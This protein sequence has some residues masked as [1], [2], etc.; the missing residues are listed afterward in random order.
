MSYLDR[1]PSY[2]NGSY[3]SSNQM[4]FGGLARRH[5][6]RVAK[7][8]NAGSSPL[9]NMRGARVN[10]CE[11]SRRFSSQSDGMA[12][13]FY[14]AL[15]KATAPT[16]PAQS[17]PS[18]QTPLDKKQLY[19]DLS[20]GANNGLDPWC[21]AAPLDEPQF[22]SIHNLPSLY[23]Y[24]PP[25]RPLSYQE[26]SDSDWPTYI[27]MVSSSYSDAGDSPHSSRSRYYDGGLS[28]DTTAVNSPELFSYQQFPEPKTPE[29][30]LSDSNIM[31]EVLVGVGLY[32]EPDTESW[33]APLVAHNSSMQSFNG[34]LFGSEFV[35]GKGLTL[36]EAFSPPPL[37][38]E[39]EQDDD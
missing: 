13:S 15:Q 1:T 2:S 3:D 34:P 19:I 29:A 17:Y 8:T 22:E 4:P 26:S 18:F 39:N 7:V 31:G 28:T 10:R 25:Q 38:S 16:M 9:G 33:D 37:E 35:P 32:N 24:S 14:A 5:S 27:P 11:P 36:E 21:H 23:T 30:P 20:V 12:S 6:N